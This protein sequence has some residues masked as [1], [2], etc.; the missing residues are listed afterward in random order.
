[1]SASAAQ[2]RTLNLILVGQQR[3]GASALQSSIHAHPSAA[4]YDRLFHADPQVRAQAY[5]DHFDRDAPVN[6][7]EAEQRSRFRCCYVTF[8]EVS[9]EQYLSTHVFDNPP[10]GETAVGVHLDYAAIRRY[11]MWEYFEDWCRAGDF[12]ML[13]LRRNPVACYV[14]LC[15]ARQTG[16][17]Q[18]SVNDRSRTALP[19]SVAV[20]PDELT[21]F[22][23][24]YEMDAGKAARMCDD[25]LEIEYRDLLMDYPR[26]MAEVFRFLNLPPLPGV[27]APVR[28]L[29]NRSLVERISNYG[30]LKSSV[31]DDVRR[32]FNDTLL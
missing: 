1:M 14:S 10:Q 32:Y 19:S 31:P 11:Q 15:Q 8:A 7:T 4:C 24:N 16:V 26:V 6:E 17:W 5:Q 22:C 18:R 13:H 30:L 3:C 12:C 21:W 27:C 2:S 28:R 25:R 20:D 23:R 29:R 9:P